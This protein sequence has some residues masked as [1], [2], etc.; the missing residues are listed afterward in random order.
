M[1]AVYAS[2]AA[3]CMSYCCLLQYQQHLAQ[4]RKGRLGA[5]TASAADVM[6]QPPVMLR[7]AL[8]QWRTAFG[9]DG[10]SMQ[11]VANSEWSNEH[12]QSDTYPWSC[13]GCGK[14]SQPKYLSHNGTHGETHEALRLP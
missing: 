7:A 13:P 8:P 4:G 3:L 10:F 5:A 11:G 2:P 1:P 14:Y 6:V 9:E 12:I